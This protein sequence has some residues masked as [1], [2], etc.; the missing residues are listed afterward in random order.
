MP[1]RHLRAPR[2]G[3]THS[4][5]TFLPSGLTLARVMQSKPRMSSEATISEINAFPGVSGFVECDKMGSVLQAEGDDAETYGGVL[6]YFEQMANLIGESFGLDSIEEAQ[7]ITP[8]RCALCLPKAD[9]SVGVI[10]DPKTKLKELMP[11]LDQ[12]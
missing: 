10:Y 11:L 2:L 3:R 7:I 12:L 8:S 6:G 4:R 1:K 5:T 9:K